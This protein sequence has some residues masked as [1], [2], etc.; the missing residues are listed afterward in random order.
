MLQMPNLD[1]NE[2]VRHERKCIIA[3]MLRSVSTFWHPV[4]KD[5][6]AFCLFSDLHWKRLSGFMLRCGMYSTWQQ[7]LYRNSVWAGKIVKAWP[8]E[9]FICGTKVNWAKIKNKNTGS[10]SFSLNH[11]IY[12]SL[13]ILNILHREL[14]MF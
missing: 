4:C 5:T 1:M 6:Y 14:M 7:V 3:G 10:F 8:G 13:F 2:T 12:F 11:C 9:H